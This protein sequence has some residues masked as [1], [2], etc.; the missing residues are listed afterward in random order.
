MTPGSRGSGPGTSLIGFQG[1]RVWDVE[2]SGRQ[3]GSR[4]KPGGKDRRSRRALGSRVLG[5]EGGV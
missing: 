4:A 3:K 5:K 1:R 2:S